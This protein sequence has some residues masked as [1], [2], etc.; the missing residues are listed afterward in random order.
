MVHC[1]VRWIPL[2]LED[3]VVWFEKAIIMMIRN[4]SLEICSNCDFKCR[5]KIHPI[6]ISCTLPA[7]ANV[8]CTDSYRH[9][10]HTRHVLGCKYIK[11][12]T[13]GGTHTS[14]NGMNA[15]IPIHLVPVSNGIPHSKKECS[16]LNS[17]VVGCWWN[18]NAN[19]GRMNNET[20]ERKVS[21]LFPP[22]SHQS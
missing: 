4:Y 2:V 6:K 21:F 12:D 17:D 19:N 3:S 16:T 22:L 1:S 14:N 18:A 10:C 8:T 13:N 5:T 15:S 7:N 20:C 11:V 9:T